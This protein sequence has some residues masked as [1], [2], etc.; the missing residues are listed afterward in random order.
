MLQ[1]LPSYR[2]IRFEKRNDSTVIGN[3][4]IEINVAMDVVVN[5]LAEPG[6]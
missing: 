3:Y 6:T 5:V 2:K 1:F 4:G